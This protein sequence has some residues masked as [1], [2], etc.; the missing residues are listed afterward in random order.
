M[1][2]RFDS[3]GSKPSHEEIA[4]RAREIYER[5][6]RTPGRDLENWLE[7][8]SQLMSGR[9]TERDQKPAAGDPRTGTR[10]LAKPAQRA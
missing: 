7:A 1:A 5:N 4:Q 6:G 8:E 9:K 3:N 2:Q 10:T